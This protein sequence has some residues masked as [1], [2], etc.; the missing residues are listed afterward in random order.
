M[1]SLRLLGFPQFS[2]A[3]FGFGIKSAPLKRKLRLQF[4]VREFTMFL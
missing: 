2:G 4:P 1:T 3:C